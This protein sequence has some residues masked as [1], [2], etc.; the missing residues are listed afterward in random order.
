[1]QQE[2]AVLHFTSLEKQGRVGQVRGFLQ[3]PTF[4]EDPELCPVRTL[5]VYRDKVA[6]LRGDNTSLFVSYLPPHKSV[7]SRTLARWIKEILSA[8]GVDTAVW[9]PQATRAASA[10]HM[11][12]ARNL[13]LAQLC[14][15]ADWSQVS[16]VFEKFYHRYL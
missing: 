6:N 14:K 3:I 9:G 16:G 7:T 13:S 12:T 5:L 10:A 11:R 15:L 1:M 2:S 8:A 4:S